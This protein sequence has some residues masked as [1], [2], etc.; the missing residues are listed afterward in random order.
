MRLFHVIIK[1]LVNAYLSSADPNLFGSVKRR[2]GK[3]NIANEYKAMATGTQAEIDQIK[4]ENP[5]ES[6]GA[7][8]AMT[9]ASYGARQMQTR[10]LNTMGATGATPEALIATQGATNQALGSAAGEIAAGA[11]ANK[12]NRIN[13]LNS[14]KTQQMGMY[15]GMAGSAESERG[16]GW[17]TLF[18]A[19]DSLGKLASGGGQA[20][21]ALMGSGGGGGAAAAAA[22][23]DIRMKENI[24][25]IGE[26][27][28]HTIYK[29]NYI[30]DPKVIIGVMAQDIQETDPDCVV[31][32]GDYLYVDYNKLFNEVQP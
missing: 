18:Q 1:V 9:K 27:Q 11:E 25:K 13:N 26:L 2:Q 23:S 30:G 16:S 3:Q 32:V 8:A 14:L 10:M 24:A 7:K 4:A 22:G 5:F 19:M 21:G 29:F 12:Q 31:P 28:G 20:A 17:S 15:G 6:A